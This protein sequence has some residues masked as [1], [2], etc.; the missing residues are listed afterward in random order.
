M[1]LVAILF[2]CGNSMKKIEEMNIQDTLPIEQAKDVTVFY[3]DSGIVRAKLKTPSL[4]RYDNKQVRGVTKLPLGLNVIFY[5]SV[6]AEESKLSAKY[7][8]KFDQTGII[9]VKY[10]VVVVN[11]DSEK[12]FTDHLVWDERNNRI[13][14]DVFVKIIT[15]DKIIWGD[16]FESDDKFENYKILKPKG[17]IPIKDK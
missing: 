10:Y 8:E 12:L 13:Y 16:G 15:K 11:A 7:G 6:G 4:K 9:E 1:Y 3:S 2:S 17:E 5:D 14:S